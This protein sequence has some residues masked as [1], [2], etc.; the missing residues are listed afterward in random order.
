MRVTALLELV[1]LDPRL[2]D[3]L[4]GQ[5][6]GGQRQRVAIARALAVEP[7][8]LI[9]DEITSALD[10]S[11]QA[12][13]LNTMRDLQRRLGLSMLFIG[14]NLPAVCYVSDAVAV[15]HRGRIVEAGPTQAL[16]HAPQ[17]PYTKALLAAVPRLSGSSRDGAPSSG[18]SS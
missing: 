10:V 3:R 1:G 4:P 14:H 16:L 2:A 6:S 17:H 8:L 12:A 18:R 11:V 7:G 9:A 13:V 5:L 15:M